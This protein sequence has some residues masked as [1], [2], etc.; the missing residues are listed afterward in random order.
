MAQQAKLQADAEAHGPRIKPTPLGNKPKRNAP[1]ASAPGDAA[2]EQRAARPKR[3]RRPTGL[4]LLSRLQAFRTRTRFEV[5]LRMRLLRATERRA[6]H[7]YS[8]AWW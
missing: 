8:A 3:K 2:A 5:G 1:L 6:S 7:V 4:E